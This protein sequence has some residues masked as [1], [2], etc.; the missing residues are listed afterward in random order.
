[1]DDIN[2]LDKDPLLPTGFVRSDC[3][4]PRH[5][6]LFN[7]YHLRVKVAF[8][9]RKLILNE[10]DG[11]LSP[12]KTGT[13]D[14]STTCPFTNCSTWSCMF[15]LSGRLGEEGSTSFSMLR[16]SSTYRSRINSLSKDIDSFGLGRFGVSRLALY[17]NGLRRFFVVFANLGVVFTSS[18]TIGRS[19]LRFT[20]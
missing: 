16:R 4:R 7:T 3:T 20:R 2:R 18:M 14:E 6:L 17:R 1:L 19:W 11:R 8:L 9:S 13:F 15:I 5:L 12:V 10:K